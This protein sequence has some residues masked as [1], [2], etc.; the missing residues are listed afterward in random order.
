MYLEL[1]I[2]YVYIY[3]PVTCIPIITVN[4]NN[5]EYLFLQLC[6]FDVLYNIKLCTHNDNKCTLLNLESNTCTT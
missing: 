6:K 4:N 2:G 5:Y 3:A 1:T